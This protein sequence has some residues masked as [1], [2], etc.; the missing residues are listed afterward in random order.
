M[1]V[2]FHI[3]LLEKGVHAYKHNQIS[4]FKNFVKDFSKDLSR[5]QMY[6]SLFNQTLMVKE[7]CLRVGIAG[8]M[9]RSILRL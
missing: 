3:R 5:R 6:Q 1:R 4:P 8:S 2:V 7:Q 9:S